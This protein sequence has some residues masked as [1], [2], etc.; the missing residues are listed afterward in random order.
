MQACHP[1]SLLS[2]PGPFLLPLA[3]DPQAHVVS[4]ARPVGRGLFHR[5]SLPHTVQ[6]L[7]VPPR[8]WCNKQRKP[9][10]ELKGN[11]RVKIFSFTTFCPK[12]IR[13]KKINSK[14]ANEKK[15]IGF[16]SVNTTWLSFLLNWSIFFSCYSLGF[17]VSGFFLSF[18]YVGF[19]VPLLLFATVCTIDK[20][21]HLAGSLLIHFIAEHIQEDQK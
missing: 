1:L 2:I 20:N 12:K 19:A 18:C 3:R 14:S 4:Q 16:S 17:G 7:P 8:V 6:E 11:H 21:I 9:A 10:A 13:S 5:T 15:N